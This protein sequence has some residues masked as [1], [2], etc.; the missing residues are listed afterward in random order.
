MSKKKNKKY[1]LY[2]PKKR[3][4]KQFINKMI[5]RDIIMYSVLI[6]SII[7]LTTTTSYAYLSTEVNTIELENIVSSTIEGVEVINNNINIENLDINSN[8]M[9]EFTVDNSNTEVAKNVTYYLK[10]TKNTF[11]NLKFNVYEGTKDT[12]SSKTPLFVSNKL[13]PSINEVEITGLEDYIQSNSTQTYTILFNLEKVDNQELYDAY[14]EFSANIFIDL[15]VT[16]NVG[17]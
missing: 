2:Q 11:S 7:L 6:L 5:K 4:S 13:N 9:Y 12:V 1:K 17:E 8:Y 16:G 10:I 3:Q 14:K 15:K